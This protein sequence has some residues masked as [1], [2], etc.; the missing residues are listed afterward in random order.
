MNILH[1]INTWPIGTTS[2]CPT[3][4]TPKRYYHCSYQVVQGRIIAMEVLFIIL[5]LMFVLTLAEPLSHWCLA[6]PMNAIK[7]LVCPQGRW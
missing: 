6:R 1:P 4:T 3:S 5:D 2:Q 7:V